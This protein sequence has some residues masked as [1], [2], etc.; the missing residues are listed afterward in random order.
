MTAAV[1][2]SIIHGRFTHLYAVGSYDGLPLWPIL[3]APVMALVNLFRLQS[4]A[5]ATPA[6]AD[7]VLPYS[8]LVGVVL[9]H[10]GRT[11]AWSLGT[12]KRLWVIQ[13][14]LVLGV[15]GARGSRLARPLV[16]AA[17]P[18]VAM[19]S[20]RRGAALLLPIL[21]GLLLLRPLAEPLL[22]PYYLAPGLALLGIA[23]VVGV[24]KPKLSQLVLPLLLMVWAFQ[25]KVSGPLWW[26]VALA[27]LAGA[28]LPAVTVALALALRS[29]TAPV[30]PA[31][32]AA[33]GADFAAPV[34]EASTARLAE[35]VTA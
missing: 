12:R 24:E 33:D 7:L 13:V 17:A 18:L 19:F 6:F 30:P 23:G 16:L 28:A 14:F 29:R 26:G 11:L 35:A 32:P 31:P 5:G 27:L 25:A 22:F 34:V 3:L 15:G 2:Q 1:A 4:T 20:R 10:A 9:L 8:L 21:A